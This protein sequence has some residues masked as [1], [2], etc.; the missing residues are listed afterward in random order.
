MITRDLG[1]SFIYILQFIFQGVNFCFSLLDSI[2]FLGTSLLNFL[3]AIT[4]LGALIPIV[5]AV[6]RNRSSGSKKSKSD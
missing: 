5:F 1:D 3:I 6:V 4:I 2:T